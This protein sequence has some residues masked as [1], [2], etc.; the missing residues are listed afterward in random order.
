MAAKFLNKE[1]FIESVGKLPCLYDTS[2]KE[3]T[4]KMVRENAWKRVC[5]EVFQK[6]YHNENALYM[7]VSL[8]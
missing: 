5:E 4:D 1:H 6:A 3:C 8:S 7:K 2:T